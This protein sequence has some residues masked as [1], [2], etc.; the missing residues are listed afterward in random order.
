M[1]RADDPEE[2][3][4]LGYPRRDGP[5]P[6][7]VVVAIAW[8]AFGV[9]GLLTALL[10]K[11]GG[12]AVFGLLCVLGGG[13][14]YL[15]QRTR[16]QLEHEEARERADP[17]GEAEERDEDAG[18]D[19]DADAD[20]D[21]PAAPRSSSGGH[22]TTVY[23]ANEHDDDIVDAEFTEYFDYDQAPAD[24]DDGTGYDEEEVAY[25]RY[26]ADRRARET[27]TTDATVDEEH[28]DDAPADAE[29]GEDEDDVARTSRIPTGSGEQGGTSDG[30][31]G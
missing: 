2:L 5:V 20:A 30:S 18:D 21:E 16:E 26:Q 13:G 14:L 28:D 17:F 19:D 11:S 27:E 6:K 3:G 25:Q 15:G 23:G 1:T 31:R 10:M 9:V 24:Q 22:D 7:L 4:A 29:R 8:A 12:I